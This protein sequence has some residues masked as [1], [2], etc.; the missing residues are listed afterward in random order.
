ML[1][2]LPKELL[3]KLPNELWI[4]INKYS[5]DHYLNEKLKEIRPKLF[6]YKI[7]DIDGD[8]PCKKYIY[9]NSLFEWKINEYVC[10]FILE[11]E[12]LV[13]N[14]THGVILYKKKVIFKFETLIDDNEEEIQLIE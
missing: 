10:D 3:N 12:L 8:L 13:S 11:D 6:S 9:R 1:K 14:I 4:M 2:K 5:V 7:T